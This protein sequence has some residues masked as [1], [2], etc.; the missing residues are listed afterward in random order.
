MEYTLTSCNGHTKTSGRRA[1][2][3][4]VKSLDGNTQRRLPTLTE[5]DE[6]PNERGEIPVPEV[7]H[8]YPHLYDIEA[9]IPPMNNEAEILLLIGRDLIESH[10][11]L[12]Q[13]L[14]PSRTP[15][16]QRLSL[17][18]D[19]I[20]EPCLG[21]VHTV[22]LCIVSVIHQREMSRLDP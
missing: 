14:G 11:V 16:A 15:H 18:C 12:D 1:I 20:G 5:C 6:I 3:L 7:A 2:G 22:D 17:G 10:H 9:A 4:V 8:H 21:T 19:I 13:R